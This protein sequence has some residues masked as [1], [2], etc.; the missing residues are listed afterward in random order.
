MLCQM[1]LFVILY[2]ATNLVII[3][4]VN[5]V[6]T[7]MIDENATGVVTVSTDAANFPAGGIEESISFDIMFNTLSPATAGI[8]YTVSL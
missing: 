1:S 3:L 6:S 4:H 8:K 7:T 5:S 2:A